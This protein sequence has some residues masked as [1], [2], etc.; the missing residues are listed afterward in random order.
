[1]IGLQIFAEWIFTLSEVILYF[2]LVHAMKPDQFPE[3]KQRI[4]LTVIA[5]SI[6]SGVVLLNLVNF[7]SML[8]TM[9]YAFLVFTIGASILY[10]GKFIELFFINLI[11][12]SGLNLV[13]GILLKIVGILGSP[14]IVK[15]VVSG[16]SMERLLVVSVF[17]LI[18]IIMVFG[19]CRLIPHLA[20]KLKASWKVVLISF[21]GCITSTFWVIQ[22]TTVINLNVSLFESVVGAVCVLVCYLCYFLLQL[23]K[24]RQ[25]QE[26]TAMENKLLRMNYEA[27]EESYESNAI[28]Y[29]DMKNHFLLL[30]T[31]MA[32]DKHQEA[33]EYCYPAN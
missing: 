30:Q 17:K 13:E 11:Y 16:F 24:I 15:K 10:K 3:K 27:A 31:Y 33:R 28:L 7:T 12:L 4:F 14:E 20:L 2:V 23:W 19:I 9:L 18:E 22:T 1:M 5:G 6:A 32:E 25:E 29:H 26:Y 8:M 21:A